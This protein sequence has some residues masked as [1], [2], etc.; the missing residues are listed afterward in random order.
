M[1]RRKPRTKKV[2]Q[3]LETPG[4]YPKYLLSVS[5]AL[6]K[7]Y[8]FDGVFGEG[9]T[10]TAYRLKHK[11]NGRFYCLKTIAER[12]RGKK[13]REDVRKSLAKE[14][15]ILDPLRHRSLPA[16]YQRDLDAALP[17]YVCT[18][19]GGKTLTEFKAGGGSLPLEHSV[20]VIWSLMDV[21][22][23]LHEHHRAHCDLHQNN[24]LLS[25]EVF[26]DGIL[27]IDFGSGHRES[28]TAPQTENRGNVLF[29]DNRSQALNRESVSRSAFR[30]SFEGFDFAALGN[31]LAIM[32]PCFF[33]DASRAHV[34]AYAAFCRSL[35]D[36][37][38][39]SWKDAHE[40]FLSVIDPHR[41]VTASKSLFLSDVGKP[42]YITIPGP[43][44]VPIGT[45]C[46]SV[47]NTPAFQRLRAIRQLSFCEFYFPGATHTRF[48]HS[49][50]VF[51]VAKE[52]VDHLVH[53]PEFADQFTEQN[54]RGL[55][56]ASLLHDVGHYP[57]AH[58]I[59]QYV[60]GRFPEDRDAREIASHAQH[61]L[62]LI[63][64][65]EDLRAAIIKDWGENALI[66]S[67]RILQGTIPVLSDL[68][69][70]P[71][72][73]DKIDYLTRDALH[74][75]VPYGDGLDRQTLLRTICCVQ[76]GQSLGIQERGI[77]ATEGLMILQDQ[78][79]G[80]V[81][82]QEIVRGIICM[83]HMALAH[84]VGTGVEELSLFVEK[85]KAAHGDHD[86]LTNVV[87]PAIR[88]AESS[89]SKGTHR[90]KEKLGLEHLVRFHES[91]RFKDI[92]VPI[93]AYKQTDRPP[94]R[95]SAAK[96][97][98]EA[99]VPPPSLSMSML[100]IEWRIVKVLRNCFIAA[101]KEK[102]V[103]LATTELAVDVPYGKGHSRMV[104]VKG[105]DGRLDYK[106]TE[107]S[108][109]NP[110]I[111]EK[112]AAFLSVVRIYVPRHI[113]LRMESFLPSVRQSAEDKFYAAEEE[114][115]AEGD[116]PPA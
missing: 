79:L 54:I 58:V 105:T 25:G 14:V 80:S 73:I 51:G 42:L 24:V 11:T 116:T 2:S 94:V 113:Y 76:N 8:A 115:S 40:R 75:G 88:A 35:K 57:F 56:L 1:G 43:R 63:D 101:F 12:V 7:E 15:S 22:K 44:S 104:F 32:Q 34:L 81:Y 74:C 47:I 4:T 55:L 27:I 23:Y 70:G 6:E 65:D 68:V 37:R 111:F 98:F 108:H 36:R 102:G 31:L 87:L 49:L 46:L 84:V 5:E 3:Q 78:M 95:Y 83:F 33:G 60:A 29:K 64:D 97:I 26:R 89:A 67:K 93:V 52:A 9:K 103:D 53:D 20:Y 61:S 106:I 114:N 107:A 10:G 59:E 72:D 13:K 112:P 92:Y 109:L 45:A 62:K 18:S 39:E 28:G 110:T 91:P 90:G 99:I 30:T 77:A 66:E 85:L 48:E 69:D 19:H 17:Y 50:G 100:P 82:W 86:A 38:I 41:I 21:L 16:I 96:T 71:I